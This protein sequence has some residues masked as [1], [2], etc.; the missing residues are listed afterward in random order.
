MNQNID[1]YTYFK[2]NAAKNNKAANVWLRSAEALARCGVKKMDDLANIGSDVDFIRHFINFEST[3]KELDDDSYD[4]ASKMKAKYSRDAHKAKLRAAGEVL[5]EDYFLAH[6]PQDAPKGIA[7]RAASGLRRRGI[8][9]MRQ[10]AETS[11]STI[12]RIHNIGGKTLAVALDMREKYVV[13][14]GIRN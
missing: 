13:E 5:V 8:E 3:A 4:F 2:E 14:L 7:A 1:V 10:L 6:A 11:P 12:A 9:T